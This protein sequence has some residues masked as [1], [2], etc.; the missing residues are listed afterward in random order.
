MSL[1]V[2]MVSRVASLLALEEVIKPNFVKGSGTS[3]SGEVTPDS[4]SIQIGAHHHDRRIPADIRPNVSLDVDV[5]REPR[6]I[7]LGDGVDI[8]A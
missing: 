1:E 5:S 2:H 3:K 8:R 7:S 6:F 4:V